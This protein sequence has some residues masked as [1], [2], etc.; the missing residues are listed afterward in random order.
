M[1][2]EAYNVRME[3]ERKREK[4]AL[5]IIFISYIVI[6][7]KAIELELRVGSMKSH[8]ARKKHFRNDT[9]R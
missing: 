1:S 2:S 7:M 4:C 8:C 9:I 5:V 3:R 6:I